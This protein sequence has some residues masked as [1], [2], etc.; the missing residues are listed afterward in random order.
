MEEYA[1]W[2]VVG[3]ADVQNLPARVVDALLTLNAEEI[4]ERNDGEQQD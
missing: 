2:R 4:R 1:V 3:G